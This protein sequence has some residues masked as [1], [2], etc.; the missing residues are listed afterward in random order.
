M[1]LRE[2]VNSRLMDELSSNS[3]QHAMQRTVTMFSEALGSLL[4]DVFA[5]KRRLAVY[6]RNDSP[7]VQERHLQACINAA[8][9]W[10]SAAIVDNS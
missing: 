4:V 6:P 7:P 9:L 5:S 1:Q 10:P 3:A 8:D 2:V